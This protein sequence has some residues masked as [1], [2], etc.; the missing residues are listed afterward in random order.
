MLV[1]RH[2]AFGLLLVAA[3]LSGQSTLRILQPSETINVD[4]PSALMVQPLR[5]DQNNNIYARLVRATAMKSPITKISAD[6]KSVREFS[7]EGVPG[8]KNPATLDFAIDRYG[9]LF[10]LVEGPD[11]KILEFDQDGKHKD[12]ITIDFKLIPQQLAVF[13]TGDFALFGTERPLGSKRQ[14]SA[15]PYAGL[16]DRSGRFLRKIEL[17]EKE[18]P[19]QQKALAKIG[20]GRTDQ[21]SISVAESGA[22]GNVY[23]A[24][25]TSSGPV[26][27]VSPSGVARKV[28][29]PAGPKNAVLSSIKLLPSGRLAALFVPMEPDNQRQVDGISLVILDPSSGDVLSEY[30]LDNQ[31]GIA[32][33]CYDSSGFSFLR[34]GPENRLQIVRATSR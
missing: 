7:A 29:R 13:G 19:D 6:G 24:R 26:Y 11:F 17:V 20:I 33:A 9:H 31:T 14:A 32:L 4:S 18:D 21:L 27:V 23:L 22:D 1:C 15:A 3:Q 10:M 5:C 30:G 16:F 34:S 25:P 8:L 12:T 2:V 28:V